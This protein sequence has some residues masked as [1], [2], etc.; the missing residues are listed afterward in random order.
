MSRTA[1]TLRPKPLKDR[2]LLGGTRPGFSQ[3]SHRFD[4]IQ[5]HTFP[6]Y[7]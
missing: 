1:K 5:R 6:V 4:L 7:V 2:H 3:M